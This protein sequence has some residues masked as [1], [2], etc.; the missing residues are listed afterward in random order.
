LDKILAPVRPHHPKVCG[1][2][3]FFEL[4]LFF[5]VPLT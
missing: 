4:S 1:Y 5:I 3:I 2:V